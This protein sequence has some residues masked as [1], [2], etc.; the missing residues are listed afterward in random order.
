MSELP[1][2]V[3][4]ELRAR[5]CPFCQRIAAGECESFAPCSD[6]VWFEPLNPV[7]PGHLLFVPVRHVAS[8][9]EDPYAAALTME[10]ASMWAGRRLHGEDFNLITSVGE[11]ATQTVRHLHIHLVPRRPEDGLHLPWTGQTACR[12]PKCRKLRRR[13]ADGRTEGAQGLCRACFMRWYRAGRP[14][15][16][17]DPQPSG[18]RLAVANEKHRAKAAARAEDYAELRSWGESPAAAAE[19]IGV[20]RATAAKYE[21]AWRASRREVAA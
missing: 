8:A 11:A 19:R 18:D 7:T 3:L 21:Q 10:T 15:V 6:V 16:V 5:D 1:E 17:P 4:A 14:D 12:N 13:L 20:A 2:R 9:L